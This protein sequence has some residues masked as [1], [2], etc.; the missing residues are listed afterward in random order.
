MLHHPYL[1]DRYSPELTFLVLGLRTGWLRYEKRCSFLL[2]D[3][4]EPDDEVAAWPGL[5]DQNM[6]QRERGE[7]VMVG[8]GLL[9]EKPTQNL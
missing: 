9:L 8:R 7:G 3:E 6:V 2:I 5:P 4:D 1:V